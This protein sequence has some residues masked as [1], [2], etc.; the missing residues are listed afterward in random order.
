MQRRMSAASNL[1]RSKGKI[2]PGSAKGSRAGSEK[3]SAG[4]GSVHGSTTNV[5][6]QLTVNS[7]KSSVKSSASKKK[8]VVNPVVINVDRKVM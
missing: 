6:M 3:G 1:S 7:D 2:R 4:K 5:L 8:M